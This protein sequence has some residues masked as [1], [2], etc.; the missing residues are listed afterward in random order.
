MSARSTTRAGKF[1]RGIGV[2]QLRLGCGL[3][4]FAYLVSHFLN[5]ALGNISLEA[6]AT[7]LRYHVLFWQFPPVAIAF[8]GAALTHGGLG[9]W[10]LYELAEDAL[11][12]QH[13]EIRGRSEP[14]TVRMVGSAATLAE[15]T[16]DTP[17]PLDQANPV[18]THSIDV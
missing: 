7:G 5:H 11:P 15:L 16:A 2:R 9:I 6:L 18:E 13:V 4:L 10:A 3:L 12:Q 17:R 1:V 8:Y 14:M